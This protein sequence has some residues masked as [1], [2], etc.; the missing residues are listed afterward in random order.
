MLPMTGH[1][2]VKDDLSVERSWFGDDWSVIV[3]YGPNDYLA[4]KTL[5]P[6]MGFIAAGHDFLAQ[7]Y[8]PDASSKRSMLLVKNGNKSFIGFR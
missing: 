4:G 3:N 1:E 6:P 8:Y 2:Y 5:L 7:H